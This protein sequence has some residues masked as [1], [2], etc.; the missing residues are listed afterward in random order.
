MRKLV[1]FSIVICFLAK[2]AAYAVPAPDTASVIHKTDGLADEWAVE[3][4]NFDKK[5]GVELAEANDGKNLYV[6]IRAVNPSVQIKMLQNG[7]RFF[8]DTKGKHKKSSGVEFP[9]KHPGQSGD[10]SPEELVMTITINPVIKIF[11]FAEGEPVIQRPDKVGG[12]Q[13]GFAL[14]S[15]G[16]LNIEYLIPLT[17]L[18][19]EMALL[20]Q[21]TI[22]LGWLINGVEEEPQRFQGNSN[23]MGGVPNN[24][25][26]KPS[27]NPGP[28]IPGYNPGMENMLNEQEFW[29]RYT[30][31]F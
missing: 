12:V 8:I 29:T 9:L 7:M 1:L 17:I 11:G 23:L 16:V 4:F 10:L 21:K 31:Y 27:K 2:K 15:A 18:E 25:I 30:I 19:K 26:T 3:Q 5:N 28:E 14:D 22:S 6:I 13:L 20:N 24:G